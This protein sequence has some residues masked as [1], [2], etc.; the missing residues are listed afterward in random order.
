MG[1]PSQVSYRHGLMNQHWTIALT[2]NRRSADY[3]LNGIL[4]H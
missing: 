2:P 3:R 1:C 4:V